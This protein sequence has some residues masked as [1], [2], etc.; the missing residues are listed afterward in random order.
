MRCVKGRKVMKEEGTGGRRGGAKMRKRNNFGPP[1][2]TRGKL[3]GGGLVGR[4]AHSRNQ[5]DEGEGGWGG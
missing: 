1:W 5:N 4:W 3:R 2:K